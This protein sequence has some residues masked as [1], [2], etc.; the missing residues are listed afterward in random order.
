MTRFEDPYDGAQHPDRPDP[1]DV[2]DEWDG[3]PAWDRFDPEL[4]ADLGPTPR[5]R[6]FV[7]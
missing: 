3:P 4:D 1:R 2:V 5:P 6:R 7:N